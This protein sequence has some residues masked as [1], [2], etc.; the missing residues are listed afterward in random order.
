MVFDEQ[1]NEFAPRYGYKRANDDLNDWAIPLK[2][3]EDPFNDPFAQRKMDKKQRVLKNK[4]Q[5]MRNIVSV[6]GMSNRL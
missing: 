4:G 1:K 5:Q 6:L 3:G 2:P